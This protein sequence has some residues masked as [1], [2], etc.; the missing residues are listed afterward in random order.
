MQMFYKK[1]NIFVNDEE[2]YTVDEKLT[3][4]DAE[5]VVIK[6]LGDFIN[7]EIIKQWGGWLNDDKENLYD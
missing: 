7:E 6:M 1:Y 2:K 4:E 5:I 3:V